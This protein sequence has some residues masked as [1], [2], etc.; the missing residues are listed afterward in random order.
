MRIIPVEGT[1]VLKTYEVDN[2]TKSGI[3]ISN[4][5]Q[6]PD[7]ATV[8][9]VHD[10]SNFKE[11]DLVCFNRY[12]S[13]PINLPMNEDKLFVLPEKEVLAKIQL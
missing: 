6:I 11:G 5:E 13:T 3:I 4:N 9:E 8:I 7:L 2:K 12:A 10:S 1:L